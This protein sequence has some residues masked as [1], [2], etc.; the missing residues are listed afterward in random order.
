MSCQK[1]AIVLL[2]TPHSCSQVSPCFQLLIRSISKNSSNLQ[3]VLMSIRRQNVFSYWLQK[4]LKF[5]V[6]GG[7]NSMNLTHTH[8]HTRT[9]CLLFYVCCR[10]LSKCLCVCLFE[11][12]ALQNK[13]WWLMSDWF[14][15]WLKLQFQFISS[16][17]QTRRSCRL[18]KSRSH[19]LQV[20]TSA[21]AMSPKHVVFKK[22]SRDKSVSCAE[23]LRGVLL[24]FEHWSSLEQSTEPSVLQ[25]A[26]YMAKRDFV[27]HGDLV[28]PVGE[29]KLNLKVFFVSIQTEWCLAWR[30]TADSELL[31][32]VFL[33]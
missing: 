3:T 11:K 22:I 14:K 17:V 15:L 20:V 32:D 18:S 2:S 25:V 5:S 19:V 13:H 6:E 7:L 12:S 23:M 10:W 27:D 29:F 16:R 28:D 21:F 8:T 30:P 31:E 4:S 26:V 33:F 9:K 24:C 1:P